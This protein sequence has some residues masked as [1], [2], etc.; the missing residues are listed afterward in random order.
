MKPFGPLTVVLSSLLFPS[1]G[2][3]QN[4]GRVEWAR[5]DDYMYL[6]SS[7]ATLDV[8]KTLQYGEILEITGNYDNYY[9]ARTTKGDTGYVPKA[10]IVPLE[11]LAST[12]LPEAAPPSRQRTPYDERPKPAVVA[13]APKV[14]GF[15]LLKDTPVRVRLA[16]GISSATAH[17]GDTVEFEVLED[18]LVD[19]VVVI[20]RGAQAT[21]PVAEAEPKKHSGTTGRLRSASLRCG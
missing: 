9:A 3:A 15:V 6:Y 8:R 18:V 21:G 7:V 14:V 10:A 4:T 16:K 17:P 19:G 20:R 12:G 5:S 2:R 11:D 13:A 1:P